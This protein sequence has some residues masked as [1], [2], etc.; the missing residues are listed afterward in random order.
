MDKMDYPKCT[1]AYTVKHERTQVMLS[2][3]TTVSPVLSDHVWT[4]EKWSLDRGRM[5]G[6]CTIEERW[7]FNT[8]G[9]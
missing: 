1:C 9:L 4:T 5:N 6:T 2:L 8:G 3:C 7:S